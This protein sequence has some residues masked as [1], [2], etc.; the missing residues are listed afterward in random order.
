ME[1][2]KFTDRQPVKGVSKNT[3]WAWIAVTLILGFAWGTRIDQM[4]AVFGPMFGV[5]VDTS[6]VE[7]AGLQEVYRTLRAE[8]DGDLDTA[9]LANGAKRGLAEATGDPYTVFMDKDEAV[10]FR[11]QIDGEVT[12]IGAEIGVRNGQPT[13]MRVLPGS[14]AEA[15][16]VKKGDIIAGIND[17]SAES[18]GAGKAAEQIRGQEGTTV[19]ITMLRNK[20][21]KEFSIVRQ[22]VDNPSV[23]YSIENGIGILSLSRFDGETGNLAKKAAQEF[24]KAGVRGVIL[25]LRGN[26]G[27]TLDSSVEVASLWLRDKTVVTEKSRSGMN[28]VKRSVGE[29]ILEGIKTV[30]LVDNSSASAS[31]IVAGALQDHRAATLVGEKTYGKGSVQKVIDLRGEAILKVTIAKWYTPAD[32]NINGNGIKPDQEV[33]LT[34]ADI[35]ADRDLQLDAAK[36]QLE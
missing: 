34:T 1:T 20:E 35:D 36:K 23:E 25:D 16:G 28:I 5:K 10:E 6:V 21:F 33:K 12:G 29:P 8:Y 14:P 3:F 7:T 31:E 30:V 27:G 4:A 22:K 32:Q 13:I 2:D 26:G 15:A 24:K 9:K 11:K 19:K 18:V 17:I